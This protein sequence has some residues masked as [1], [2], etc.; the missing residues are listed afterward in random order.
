MHNRQLFLAVSGAND[1]KKLNYVYNNFN[2][3]DY[4]R[5]KQMSGRS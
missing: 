1:V 4:E 5:Y 2:N 3:L